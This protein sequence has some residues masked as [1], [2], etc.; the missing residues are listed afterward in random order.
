VDEDSAVDLDDGLR[1]AEGARI[2]VYT[3][4]VGRVREKSLRRIAKLT[5]GEY[6]PIAG[7]RGAD[8]ARSIA[9][10]AAPF[11]AP[12]PPTP[13]T[14]PPAV[15]APPSGIAP[16]PTVL[17]TPAH[18]PAMAAGKTRR[19]LWPW[20]LIGGVVVLG[21]AA[22]AVASRRGRDALC[23]TCRRPLPHPFS[24]CAFCGPG[25]GEKDSTTLKGSGLSD[26][27][28]TRL[29][30]TEEHL[31]KT[32]TLQDRPVLKVTK[33]L[34]MGR[35]F[36]LQTGSTTSIGRA[37][38]NDIALED[39]AVS[40]EHC[41]VRQEDGRFVV[42]DLKSTNGTFVNDR[43][44]TRHPLEDGDVLQVGET[45]LTFKREHRRL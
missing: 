17:A 41:R 27:M 40:S 33:G 1:V 5:G 24:A 2:P 44:V 15:G 6:V 19:A 34:G 39:V 38:A 36:E 28:M 42:H 31:D 12:T 13:A 22:A 7:A 25:D 21:V 4:G 45:W 3:I 9:A 35:S 11:A 23:P 20:V 10:A 37:R 16:V 29:D 14:E 8:V 18:E 43:R 32:I 26:T 30:T